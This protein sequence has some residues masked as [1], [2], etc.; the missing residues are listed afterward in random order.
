MAQ[1]T[2]LSEREQNRELNHQER[3]QGLLTISS[4]P[5]V[6]KIEITTRCNL[7]C[8]MCAINFSHKKRA[9]LP[10]ATF[11]TLEPLFPFLLSA[12]LY[13][14][15]EPLMHPELQTMIDAL[16]EAGVNTGIITNGVLIDEQRARRWVEAGLYK[17][18]IS[19]D[20]ATKKTYEMIR[21]GSSFERLR[22]NLD[23]M[24]YY[25][26]QYGSDKPFLTFNFVTMRSNIHELSQL[27]AMAHEYNVREVIVSDLL[28][29][30]DSM[31][32]EKLDFSD[33]GLQEAYSEAEVRAKDLGV[34][35]FLPKPF[36]AWRRQQ[37]SRDKALPS[38]TPLRYD[39]PCTEPWSSFWL[40]QEGDVTPCCYWFKTMGNV[41]HDNFSTIWNNQHYRTL[42]AEVNSSSRPQQCRHC[43]IP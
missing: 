34:S 12:Y 16:I 24:A 35:L 17:I 30:D 38:D 33:K 39:P 11:K 1:N 28:V 2:A 31:K 5:L 8:R 26:K 25:K 15:G 23:I 3:A 6:A 13:G 27:V 4:M 36:L 40:S 10:L 22:D 32:E 37:I 20:G 18:S 43:P 9:D 14:I 19:I 21:R 42:R 7:A 41:H 29:F